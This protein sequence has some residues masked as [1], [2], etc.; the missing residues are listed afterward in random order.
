MKWLLGTIALLLLGLAF[1]LGLLVYGMY[2]LLG[3]LVVSRVLAWRWTGDL[4]AAR[5][6]DRSAVGIGERASVDVVVRNLGKLSI[7]WMLLEDAVPGEALRQHPPRLRM[8]GAVLCLA[9]LKPRGEIRLRYEVQFL[10]RGYYP[11]GP[12]LLESGDLFGLHRRYRVVTAPHY[13]LVY[14]KVVPLEGY[15][16]ASRR[17]IGEV[18]ISHRL[19][20]DPTRIAGVRPYQR[21]DALNRIH[22]R[23]TARTGVLH[24][25]VYEPSCVAGATLVLDFHADSYQVRNAVNRIE[26][27]IT[28]AAS[29]ANAI[30]LMGEQ[31]GLVTNGRDAAERA[32]YEGGRPEFR[33]RA[34][35]RA[36]ANARERSDRLQPLVV[37]TERGEGQ[38]DRILRTLARLELTDGFALPDLLLETTSLFPRDASVIVIL[39]DVTEA[40]AIALGN[41]RRGGFAVTAVLVMFGG[42]NE[43]FDWAEPPPWAARLLAE[44][45]AYRR[46]DDEASLSQLCAERLL[47]S[48]KGP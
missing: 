31:V 33:A 9:Q 21:G 26:L 14:P 15:D 47:R 1:E 48:G 36:E 19:F 20:E 18:R 5:S 12:L 24:S 45:I 28:T 8:D 11:F 23:A 7:P 17:P 41:L 4:V 25:K 32:R 2:V 37:E 39:T 27:A 10:M 22:W 46:V 35:A 34:A 13:V 38:L 44:G 16:I 42:E 6:C 29:L 3:V 43:Y 30:F 40:A